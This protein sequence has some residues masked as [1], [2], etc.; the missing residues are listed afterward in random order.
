MIIINNVLRKYYIPSKFHF[1]EFIE[2]LKETC[3]GE[4]IYHENNSEDLSDEKEMMNFVKTHEGV[5]EKGVWVVLILIST[6][7]YSKITFTMIVE[8]DFKKLKIVS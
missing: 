8:E 3:V 5:L 2:E 1:I 6:P 4:E 7:R